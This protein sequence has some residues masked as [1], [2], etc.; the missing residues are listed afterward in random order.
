MMTITAYHYKKLRTLEEMAANSG[1]KLKVG[2]NVFSTI[3]NETLSLVTH[4]EHLP[5][6]TRDIEL[7]TGSAEELIAFIIGWQKSSSYLQNLGATSKKAIERKEQDY[8]NKELAEMIKNGK[9]NDEKA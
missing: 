4:G 5:I 7:M 1:M 9:R 2:V 3:H 6:Y 8:R